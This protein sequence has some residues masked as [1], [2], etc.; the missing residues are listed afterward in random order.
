M[1]QSLTNASA[2][3]T[4]GAMADFGVFASGPQGGQNPPPGTS[5]FPRT[6]PCGVI[7]AGT[8]VSAGA[9]QLQGSYDAVNWF[10]VGS[11]VSVTAPGVVPIPS[12]SPPQPARFVRATI[13]TA[14]TGGT[15]SVF[16]DA[17]P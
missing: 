10:S 1:I 9:V 12:V 6:Y 15:V 3:G 7:V 4:A 16:V 13:S 2:S 11:P 17:A 5:P 8:G 14:I